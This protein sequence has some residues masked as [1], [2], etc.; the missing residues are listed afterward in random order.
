MIIEKSY[1]RYGTKFYIQKFGLAM[2]ISISG[3][4]SDLVMEDLEKSI[5]PNMPFP[6]PF[7]KRYVDDILLAILPGA[8]N[9]EKILEIFNGYDR[10]LKFTTETENSETKSINFLD[11]TLTRQDDGSIKT[12]WYQ[13]EVASG[14][15]L[16]YKALNPIG[17]KRNVVTGLVDRSINFTNP[18]QRP[19]SLNRVRTLMKHKTDTQN[20]SLKKS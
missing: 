4:L 2:G 15:Y 14:R 12:K 16:N 13:K 10:N 19:E 20:N 11:M 18:E 17:H 8:E 3:F 1:F 6:I 5:L 7:Y 9:E